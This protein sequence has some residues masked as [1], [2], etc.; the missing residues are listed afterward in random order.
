MATKKKHSKR[1]LA[2]LKKLPD[3]EAKYPIAEAVGLL[4]KFDACKFDETVELSIKLGI[5]PKKPEQLLRG[6]F[7]LPHGLGKEVSVANDV[8]VWGLDTFGGG[9]RT[10]AVVYLV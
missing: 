4:K 3:P 7:A 1:Y 8:I 6:S 5:D 9:E 2:A 10:N